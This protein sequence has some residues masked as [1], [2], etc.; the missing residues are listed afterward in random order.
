MKTPTTEEKILVH[1]SRFPHGAYER[2]AVP[3]E[4]TQS[5]I[6]EV[7][8]VPRNYVAVVLGRMARAQKGYVFSETRRIRGFPKKRKVYFLTP[9]G[10]KE[11][12]KIEEKWKNRKVLVAVNE[13]IV[14]MKL[15]EIGNYVKCEDC[16]YFGIIRMD[17]EGIIEQKIKKE[18]KES[19]FVGREKEI[20]KFREIVEQV[21]KGSGRCVFLSGEPGAG[22]TTLAMKFGD[23]VKE[24]GFVFLHG[25]GYPNLSYPYL[26]IEEMLRDKEVQVKNRK[27]ILSIIKKVGTLPEEGGE[28]IEYQRIAIWHDLLDAMEKIS[29]EKP[30]A[31]FLDDLQWIDPTSLN[32]LYFICTHIRNARILIIGAY[33]SAWKNEIIESIRRNLHRD[34]IL[35]EFEIHAMQF[36]EVKGMLTLMLGEEPPE[37]FVKEIKRITAGN[38][39]F[40]VEILKKMM[41]DGILNIQERKYPSD[42]TK[43]SVPKTIEDIINER[44]KKL[45]ENARRILQ[46]SSV[47]G[48]NIPYALLKKVSELKETEILDSLDILIEENMLSP[49]SS[50]TFTFSHPL[51]SMVVYQT[52]HPSVRMLY[53]RKI[54]NGLEEI[55]KRNKEI[56]SMVDLG[57]HYEMGGEPLKAVDYYFIKA[58]KAEEIYAYE[59]S[60]TMLER[61]LSIARE[62]GDEERTKKIAIHMGDIYHRKGEYKKA[63]DSYRIALE[64]TADTEML[65]SLQLKMAIVHRES[66]NLKDAL[67][68]IE[69]G[70]SYKGK[71]IIEVKLLSEKIWLMMKMGKFEEAEKIL[72]RMEEMADEIEDPRACALVMENKATIMYY[73]GKYEEAKEYLMKAISFQEKS[74]EKYYLSILYTNLGILLAQ[75]GEMS[76]AVKYFDRSKRIEEVFNTR[77]GLAQVNTNLGIVHHKR[78]RL[79]K[80]LNYFKKAQEIYEKI[81]SYDSLAVT[82]LNIGNILTEQGYFEEALSYLNRAEEIFTHNSDLWGLCHVYT[83]I[84]DILIYLRRFGEAKKYLEKCMEIGN[85]IKNTECLSESEILRLRLHLENGEKELDTLAEN[86]EKKEI[87]MKGELRAKINYVLGT[88]YMATSRYEMAEN[89]LKSAYSL[90]RSMG[91]LAN[92]AMVECLWAEL[93]NKMG[94][95]EKMIKMA[96][97]A[98]NFFQRENM[99]Y[100]REKCDI[101]LYK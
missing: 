71:G 89:K 21:E 49:L 45:T 101:L 91:E 11:A 87:E 13:K 2:S 52:M 92:L 5:G 23:I 62:I 74:N 85:E 36:P 32:L 44:V 20:K 17:N 67:N 26:P 59:D 27:K 83:S 93:L 53:H 88:Y 42:F 37:Y 39:L 90:Y 9:A 78:G 84:S 30:I 54:A 56:E 68:S 14:E 46:I 31:I 19:I 99:G 61:A 29:S 34:G 50:S 24:K 75:T 66:G 35:T 1:L 100:W 40:I 96:E 63:L 95:K 65:K 22:K 4:I 7:I 18:L 94:E 51:I 98:L 41:E 77:Y 25:R 55:A 38:P 33:R 70:L 58:L 60:I 28:S 97:R 64:N 80:A 3:Y 10:M 47:I 15:S 73:N 57:Y 43:L 48:Y 82:Y 81:E 86:L 8:G 16:V 76:K 79:R 72:K 69:E 6:S 12:K